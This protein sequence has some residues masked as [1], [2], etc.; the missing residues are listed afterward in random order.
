[1]TLGVKKYMSALTKSCKNAINS[2]TLQPYSLYPQPLY[3][4]PSNFGQIASFIAIFRGYA[5]FLK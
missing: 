5:I 2:D 4:T 1:M 3:A